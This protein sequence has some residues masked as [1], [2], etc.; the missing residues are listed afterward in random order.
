M[1]LVSFRY[2]APR[3]E[4]ELLVLL[5]EH[6]LTRAVAGGQKARCR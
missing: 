3:S 2:L 6:G 5:G 1:K 4:D